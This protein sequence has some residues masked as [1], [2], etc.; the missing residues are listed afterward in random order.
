MVKHTIHQPCPQRQKKIGCQG[1]T[2]SEEAGLVGEECAE[3]EEER[4]TIERAEEMKRRARRMEE[5]ERR[6]VGEK[7]EGEECMGEM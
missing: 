4:I 5:K 2:E 3:C 6:K 1:Q 7:M